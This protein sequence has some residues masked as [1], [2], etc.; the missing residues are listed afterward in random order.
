MHQLAQINI[1]QMKGKDYND[2][3][4]TDFVA[5]IDRINQI[6]EASPGFVWRLKDEQD[7]A[8]NI[9]PFEDNSMLINI[10]VWEDVAPLKSF[11]YGA[12]HLEIMKRKKEWFRHFKGFYY[13]LWWIK[14]GEYPTAVEA[15]KQLTYLQ[16]K[17]PS[18]KVFTF[19]K[20]Y[21]PTV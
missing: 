13:A 21:S 6:A 7:N 1:A 12:M 3:I 15:A 9:N 8:L 20:T 18:E 19:K 4:M 14:A 11:V 10:S 16:D 5:N 2:P 17:G